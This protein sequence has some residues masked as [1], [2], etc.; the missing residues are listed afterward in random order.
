LATILATA[1]RDLGNNRYDTSDEPLLAAQFDAVTHALRAD[2][3]IFNRNPPANLT[4]PLAHRTSRA[5][6]V[7]RSRHRAAKHIV[8]KAFR[9]GVPMR[10]A[11]S[12]M[13]SSHVSPMAA[14]L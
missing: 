10:K 12:V 9:I 2:Q 3:D 4:Q 8:Q 7:P 14:R 11:L 5:F 6:V 1:Y 13:R